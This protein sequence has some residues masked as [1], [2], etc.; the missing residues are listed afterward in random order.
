MMQEPASHPSLPPP[1]LPPP[2]LPSPPLLPPPL[3]LLPPVFTPVALAQSSHHCPLLE[4]YIA[5][6]TG[7]CTVDYNC[8]ALSCA[9]VGFSVNRCDD[10][11]TVD[12]S[13][14]SGGSEVFEYSF[15]RSE[16]V[17]ARDMSVTTI[18]ARNASHLE[19]E[20]RFAC[21]CGCACVSV[22]VCA[23]VCLCVCVCVCLRI[24]VCVCACVCVRVCM[25]VCMCVHAYI[26]IY[27]CIHM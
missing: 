10:P 23:C 18:M 15:N 8:S 21:V 19:L 26:Y 7:S 20:V 4:N 1:S 5:S 16:F 2:H 9:S 6:H 11:V 17:E 27:I 12:V 24:C 13:V 22:C 14:E 3:P 25:S